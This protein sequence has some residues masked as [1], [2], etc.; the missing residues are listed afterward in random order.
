VEKIRRHFTFFNGISK[1]SGEKLS[2]KD[3]FKK[4]LSIL[5]KKK[6]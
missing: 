4:L 6:Q 1:N 5:I 2:K 3:I